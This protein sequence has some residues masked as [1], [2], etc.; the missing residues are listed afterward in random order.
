MSNIW[1]CRL[2]YMK[3]FS[4]KNFCTLCNTL[5]FYSEYKR[6]FDNGFRISNQIRLNHF[7]C[8]F[9]DE[10]NDFHPNYCKFCDNERPN[11]LC[12]KC[13]SFL[14]TS[15]CT[16]CQTEGKLINYG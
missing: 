14:K 5:I 1:V 12:I 15:N 9:C 13:G 2:C 16:D 3:N 11:Y 10:I 7:K 8:H 4:Y 6:L